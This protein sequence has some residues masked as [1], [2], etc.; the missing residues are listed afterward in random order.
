MR[1]SKT[2]GLGD[3]WTKGRC[4]VREDV[5]LGMCGL[6][7]EWTRGCEQGDVNFG[8]GGSGTCGFKD[9]D[10]RAMWTLGCVGSKTCGIEEL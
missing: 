5:D 4:G 3:D 9:M 10:L 6:V 1:D 2:L 7:D 8:R